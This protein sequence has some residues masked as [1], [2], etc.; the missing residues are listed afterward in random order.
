MTDEIII[1]FSVK[2]DGT[3]QI[4]KLNQTLGK[5]KEATKSLVPGLES[6]KAGV[7]S[8]IS[9]N[10]ALIA[11]LTAVGVVV[12]KSLKDFM[13]Y[14]DSVRQIGL[15]SGESAE[16]SSQFLQVLDDYEI[17]AQDALLATR[18]LT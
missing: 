12:G 5:T 11:V 16:K 6:A 8:F 4:E 15:L 2:D 14:G 18:A 13:A 3:P 7:T 10:A 1:R 9:A 17:S